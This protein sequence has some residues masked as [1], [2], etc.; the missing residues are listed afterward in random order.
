MVMSPT[1]FLIG[2]GPLVKAFEV[3]NNA[4]TCKSIFK[5]HSYGSI[6]S[7]TIVNDSIFVSTSEDKTA[8]LWDTTKDSPCL[9]T[10]CGHATIIYSS[11]FMEEEKTIATWDYLGNIAVWSIAKYLEENK[12]EDGNQQSRDSA[13]QD[14]NTINQDNGDDDPNIDEAWLLLCS[15]SSLINNSYIDVRHFNFK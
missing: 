8:K 9:L 6:T 10:F 7:L 1:M 12:E 15:N 13:A 11:T 2:G 5:G 14:H 3:T 4:W